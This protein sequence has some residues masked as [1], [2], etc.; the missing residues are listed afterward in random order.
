VAAIGAAVVLGAL[1]YLLWRARRAARAPQGDD[2][3]RPSKRRP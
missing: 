1:V 2:V 3:V